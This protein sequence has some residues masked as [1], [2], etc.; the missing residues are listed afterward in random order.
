MTLFA[1][2]SRYLVWF[3]CGAASA[4]A[5]KLAV[6]TLTDKPVEVLYCDTLAYEHPDNRRFMAD[7]EKWI[8]QEI[9]ILKSKEFNSIYHVFNQTKFLKGPKGAR[10]T[11]ELKKK[12]R[13][14]Y[15][16]VDDVHI[17][18]FTSDEQ[19]RIKKFYKYNPEL[20]VQM[21]L[22]DRGIDKQ[23]CFDMLVAAGIELP[24]MYK[25]GYKN[26]NCIGCVKGA[27]GYWNKIR[28]DFP[29]VFQR[30]ALHE[31]K[32]G[33]ALNRQK[34]KPV[35]LDELDPNAGNYES[36]FDIECGVLCQSSD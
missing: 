31:R 30:M 33:F 21:I 24:E 27:M 11:T 12:V 29:K 32:L 4:C 34:D 3:S 25:L 22:S 15:Q 18:G 8:G 10:C 2:E 28:V 19:T 17:F 23:A 9:K 5:A 36:E 13:D 7:V 6:D 35:F 20:Y 26:N 1:H 14:Q 16:I